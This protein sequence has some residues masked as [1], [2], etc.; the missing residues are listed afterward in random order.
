MTKNTRLVTIMV[1]MKSIQ[2]DKNQP[3]RNFDPARLK[4][5]MSSIEEHGI[6]NPLIVEKLGNGYILVD[7]ERRYR[8]SK[9]LGLK[10]VPAR[11]IETQSAVERLIRQ[12]HLQAQHEDWSAAEKA[13][14]V[15]G[16][17]KEMKLTI[18]EVGRLLALSP[19]TIASYIALGNLIERE[20]FEKSEIAIHFAERLVS[21]RK[22]A[23]SQVEAAEGEFSVD[24]E[25][26]LELELI[27]RIK[28]G[29]IK[30]SKELVKLR[31]AIKMRPQIAKEFT[32]KNSVSI[33]RLF[34]DS[35]AQVSYYHRNLV[36]S[37]NYVTNYARKGSE[38]GIQKLIT[39]H[40]QTILRRAIKT[41]ETLV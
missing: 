11:V 14:A 39:E 34:L 5:L 24:D 8:A 27:S 7:G 23:K 40:D 10:E 4:E 12:F 35:K 37:A 22:F 29:E 13:K 3:R 18:A 19:R 15:A 33:Q 1:P 9:E 6:L 28:K 31:D 25:A 21:L 30:T 20:N 17:A 2:A 38:L 32:K 36:H 41:L 16:L 26:Q